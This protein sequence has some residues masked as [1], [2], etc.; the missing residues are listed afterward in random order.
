MVL[1]ASWHLS[2]QGD[3]FLLN[4][5]WVRGSLLGSQVLVAFCYCQDL[6]E[7]AGMDGGVGSRCIRMEPHQAVCSLAGPVALET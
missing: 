5:P 1:T 4:S 6:V 7:I 3:L 2:V